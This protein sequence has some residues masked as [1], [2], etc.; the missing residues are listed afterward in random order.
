[1]QRLAQGN[2]RYWIFAEE[3]MEGLPVP[4]LYR[5]HDIRASSILGGI[6]DVLAVE[7]SPYLLNP[8]PCLPPMGYLLAA[9]S[10]NKVGL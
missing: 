1:M 8:L 6:P 3:H 9:A 10:D 4:C 7:T 2:I 5:G